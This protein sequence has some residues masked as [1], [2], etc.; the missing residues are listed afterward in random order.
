MCTD[1]KILVL[2]FYSSRN[3][4]LK[5]LPPLHE[6]PLHLLAQHSAS[7]LQVAPF[8]KQ[9]PGSSVGAGVAGGFGVPGDSVGGGV[10]ASPRHLPF[11]ELQSKEQQS[12]LTLHV[13]EEQV[14]PGDSVGGGVAGVTGVSVGGG[15][16][17]GEPPEHVEAGASTL[18]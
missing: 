8:P 16:A 6:P 11:L 7:L 17:G 15:V 9:E 1:A 3:E 14:P 12:A 10:T 4:V 5:N 13:V 18:F 2:Y